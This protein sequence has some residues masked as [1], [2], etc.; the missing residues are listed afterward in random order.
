MSRRQPRRLESQTP[1]V[2]G[3]HR[4]LAAR[5]RFA[6]RY[7]AGHDVLDLG[8]GDGAGAA[9]LAGPA[10]RV[11]GLDP[12]PS[13]VQRAT[14]RYRRQNLRFAVGGP[15]VR[16]LAP[17]SF[18]LITAFHRLDRVTD[19]PNFLDAARLVLRPL[20]HLL[21]A[22]ANAAWRPSGVLPEQFP[23]DDPALNLWELHD[24][25]ADRFL[26]ER[27]YGQSSTTRALLTHTT[28]YVGDSPGRLDL[29]DRA[30]AVAGPANESSR[31]F[32]AVCRAG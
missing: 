7:A 11:V 9:R 14:R 20:G 21:L 29:A 4:E 28:A 27:L 31:F 18:G 8:C 1:I 3:L 12:V 10:V 13:L 5:Y 17:Q 24:L 22:V 6:V 30:A 32:V 23:S 19:W 25:L 15:S 26:V 2:S 16:P